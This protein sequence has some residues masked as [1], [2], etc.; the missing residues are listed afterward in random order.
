MENFM[1]FVAVILTIV[2]C[3]TFVAKFGITTGEVIAETK[4]AVDFVLDDGEVYGIYGTDYEIGAEH[5]LLFWGEEI[6][7]TI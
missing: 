7:Y 3:A 2:G 6:I 4:N 1:K 5:T